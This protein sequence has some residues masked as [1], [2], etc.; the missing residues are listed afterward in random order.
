MI[1][2]TLNSCCGQS[3]LFMQTCEGEQAFSF[4]MPTLLQQK[5]SNDK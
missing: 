1:I 4:R 2:Y 5:E 3:V